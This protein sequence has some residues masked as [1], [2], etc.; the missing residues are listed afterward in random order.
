MLKSGNFTKAGEADPFVPQQSELE[1]FFINDSFQTC[2][3]EE[4][5]GEVSFSSRQP[6]ESFH[7]M[8]S[9][10]KMEVF[11]FWVESGGGVSWMG[12]LRTIKPGSYK[13]MRWRII[14]PGPKVL[15]LRKRKSCTWSNWGCGLNSSQVPLKISPINED[16]HETSF[17]PLS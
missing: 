15:S 10:T 2:I 7:N 6:W 14:L 13:W 11:F 3:G 9:K 4:G 1:V 12:I 5:G 8:S 16:V 17:V